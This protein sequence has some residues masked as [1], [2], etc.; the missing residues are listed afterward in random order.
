MA[1]LCPKCG[2]TLKILNDA[3]AQCLGCDARFR[4][5]RP[6]SAQPSATDVSARPAAPTETPVSVAFRPAESSDLG[7]TPLAPENKP[8]LLSASVANAPIGVPCGNHPEMSASVRCVECSTPICSTCDFSFP[9]GVHLCPKCATSVSEHLGPK[10]K[11]GVVWSY[12]LAG[13]ATLF[14]ALMSFA[15]FAG[16]YGP[17]NE[18]A[19]F[20]LGGF[21]AII[22]LIGALL[23]FSR[24][25]NRLGN[26]P[27]IIGAAI[28]NSIIMVLWLGM[29]VLA[30]VMLQG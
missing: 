16:E 18:T 2:S 7:S 15:L 20:V 9:G 14:L 1:T 10:R 26:P 24:M 28:W 4:I 29:N 12:I 19:P 8:A 30:V 11:T 23:S 21:A 5:A 22:A 27:M 6:Q 3:Q 17:G 25:D 13:A